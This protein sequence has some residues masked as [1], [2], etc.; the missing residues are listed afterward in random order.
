MPA[1][2]PCARVI[3]QWLFS[4]IIH[5]AETTPIT[6]ET[7]SDRERVFIC[8]WF[9]NKIRKDFLFRRRLI[10][11][12]RCVGWTRYSLIIPVARRSNRFP[13]IYPR[14]NRCPAI[15]QLILVCTFSSSFF[16]QVI[17]LISFGDPCHFSNQVHFLTYHQ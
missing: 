7:F 13:H 10:A 16:I 11:L 9:S 3:M 12:G 4:G 8:H 17:R 6:G 5:S 1:P 14:A 15:L 2:A